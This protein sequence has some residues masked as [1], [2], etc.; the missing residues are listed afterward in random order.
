MFDDDDDWGLG[1]V[2]DFSDDH[3]RNN[4]IARDLHDW[5]SSGGLLSE[6]PSDSE[7]FDPDEPAF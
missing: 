7:P 6:S 1:G 4:D 2:P 5:R 3:K